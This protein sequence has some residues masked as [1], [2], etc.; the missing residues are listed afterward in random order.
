MPVRGRAVSEPCERH[1][2]KGTE[3]RPVQ[4]QPPAHV[5]DDSWRLVSP[6][7]YKQRR[8][9]Q[10]QQHLMHTSA[11]SSQWQGMQTETQHSADWQA[12]CMHD[13]RAASRFHKWP[14]S[15]QPPKRMHPSATTN[16]GYSAPA[17]STKPAIDQPSA[18]GTSTLQRPQSNGRV[19]KQGTAVSDAPAAAC[20]IESSAAASKSKDAVAHA[21]AESKSMGPNDSRSVSRPM[22]IQMRMPAV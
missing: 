9:Q 19:A 11:H 12:P 4:K 15:S 7:K 20:R 22:R 16:G 18:D 3:W 8:M 21:T 17:G 1:P 5:D 2:S 6:S 10:E 13:S 14:T